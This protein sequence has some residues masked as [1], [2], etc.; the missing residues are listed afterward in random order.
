MPSDLKA[1]IERVESVGLPDALLLAAHAHEG[2]KDKA[3]MPYLTHILRVVT[4][5]LNAGGDPNLPI[6]AALHDAVED[7]C[8]SF[9]DLRL[10][11]FSEAVI[12]AVEAVTRREGE[13]YPDFIQRVCAAGD[14]A[15]AVKQIDIEDNMRPERL[16]R[17]GFE[18][19]SRL[20]AKYAAALRAIQ[21]SRS[22]D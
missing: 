15:R 12:D 7:S 5:A 4:M 18:Q 21:E 8:L 19:G 20:Q 6:A 9:D 22:H 17:L 3:G 14:L 10:N 13:N 2:Q 16:A 11:G 1:L